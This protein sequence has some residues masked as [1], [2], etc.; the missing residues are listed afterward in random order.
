MPKEKRAPGFAK[1]VSLL[2]FGLTLM[3]GASWGVVNGVYALAARFG[4][5]WPCC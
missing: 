2:A 1:T 3:T 5:S 4:W